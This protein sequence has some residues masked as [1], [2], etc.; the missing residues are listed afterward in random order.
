MEWEIADTCIQS[1]KPEFFHVAPPQR[2]QV[3]SR[4]GLGAW[5]GLPEGSTRM[6]SASGLGRN[7][8]GLKP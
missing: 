6:F 1:D 4:I 7:R 8:Y 2:K 5:H 3:Y